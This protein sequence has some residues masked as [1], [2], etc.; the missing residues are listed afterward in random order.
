MRSEAIVKDKI[1]KKKLFPF[2]GI[3]GIKRNKALYGKEMR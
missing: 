1:D 3:C 2:W